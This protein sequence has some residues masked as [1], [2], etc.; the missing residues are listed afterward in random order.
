MG[1]EDPGLGLLGSLAE[2]QPLLR[3][4]PSVS[5][6]PRGAGSCSEACCRGEVGTSGHRDK[7]RD[8]VTSQGWRREVKQGKIKSYINLKFKTADWD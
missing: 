4:P 5:S 6:G 1:L 8:K 3:L 2:S 7:A